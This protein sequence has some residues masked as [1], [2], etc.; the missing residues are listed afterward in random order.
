M[1]DLGS[2]ATTPM[3]YNEQKFDS[4]IRDPS[5]ADQTGGQSVQDIVFQILDL[6]Y[7]QT[8]CPAPPSANDFSGWMHAISEVVYSGAYFIKD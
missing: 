5:I 8:F 2:G 6:G 7:R 4:M 3:S 1:F